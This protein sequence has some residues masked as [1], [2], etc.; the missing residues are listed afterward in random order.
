LQNKNQEHFPK[1]KLKFPGDLSNNLLNINTTLNEYEAL[2]TE[3]EKGEK[4]TKYFLNLEKRNYNRKT[5][6]ELR[7]QDGVEI[8]EEKEILKV[9]QEF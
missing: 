1:G 7:K 3:L 8:R 5:I 4:P 9:I 2:K 6:N